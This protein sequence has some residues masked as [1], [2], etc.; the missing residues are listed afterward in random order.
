MAAGNC[1]RRNG[2]ASEHIGEIMIA[3]RNGGGQHHQV[4]Q[5]YRPEQQ[6]VPAQ[7]ERHDD[8]YCGV[9][10]GKAYDA[11]ER[12]E[13]DDFQSS[14]A[15]RQDN[16]GRR[17]SWRGQMSEICIDSE[18]SHWSQCRNQHAGDFGD[19][20]RA[21]KRDKETI[22]VARPLRDDKHEHGRDQ[23]RCERGVCPIQHVQHSRPT[24]EL[25]H[26]LQPIKAELAV[27]PDD[28]PISQRQ[29]RNRADV[30]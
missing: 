10:G 15:Q 13:V 25:P 26:D 4:E 12:G 23:L 17:A 18:H 30:A 28:F 7:C 24:V 2:N 3:A 16:I 1:Q 9:Q 11:I 8:R 5:D 19:D 21:R 29:I 6:L 22:E 27:H 14:V 20:R